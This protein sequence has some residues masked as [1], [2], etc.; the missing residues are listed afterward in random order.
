MN[1][2]VSII[3]VSYNASKTIEQTIQSVLNQTYKNIEYIIIDGGSTDGTVDIIKKYEDKIAF[4]VSEPDG[5]IYDAM[6]KGI[7]KSTGNI[8]G[9]INSDDWYEKNTVEKVV[10]AFEHFNYGLVYGS[11]VIIKEDGSK[12]KKEKYPLDAL[13]YKMVT[14]HSSV[15]IK[16][17]V[18]LKYGLFNL[19]YQLAADYELVLRLYSEGVKFGCLDEIL[20]NFRMGGISTKRSDILFNETIE[21]SEK[22]LERSPDKKSVK[23]EIEYYK[24]NYR[25]NQICDENYKVVKKV[26]LKKFHNVDD[27]IIVFGTGIWGEKINNLLDKNNIQ[28]R[29]FVDNDQRKWNTL[30]CGKRIEN[31]DYL[32]GIKGNIIIAVKKGEDEI[33]EQLKILC[34]ENIKLITLSELQRDVLLYG[35]KNR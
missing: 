6:N 4:W 13:W 31:L 23:R 27:G 5:G 30:F 9:I 15:F 7:L 22:Y 25:F 8:I 17:E 33:K 11:M 29:F 1:L 19:K 28:I 2:K 18:Y 32:I 34:N 20:A 35:N 10:E 16:K 3:T 24:T 21:I 26:L 14:P 12:I